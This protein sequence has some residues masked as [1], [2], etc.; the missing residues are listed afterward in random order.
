MRLTLVRVQTWS[1]SPPCD[2]LTAFDDFVCE[3]LRHCTLCGRHA[4]VVDTVIVRLD[5]LR[6]AAVLCLP[7]RNRQ[8]LATVQ[9]MLAQRY[10][11]PVGNPP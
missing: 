2:Q 10:G 1:T 5:S 8:G 11:L 4:E 3:R 6:L 9:A 7:C